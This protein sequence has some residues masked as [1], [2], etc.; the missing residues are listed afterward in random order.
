MEDY[1]EITNECDALR[2]SGLVGPRTQERVL[3]GSRLR[4]LRDDQSLDGEYYR[5]ALSGRVAF[6]PRSSAVRIQADEAK[7]LTGE[8]GPTQATPADEAKEM[9]GEPS[10][11]QATPA[12]DGVTGEPRPPRPSP[13]IPWRRIITGVI[14]LGMIGLGLWFI[15]VVV[16]AAGCEGVDD[17][18]CDAASTIAFVL[19]GL[20]VSLPG[21]PVVIAAIRPPGTVPPT[22]VA[23]CI[24]L[25]VA[26]PAAAISVLLVVTGSGN[27]AI[28]W[29]FPFPVFLF[30]LGYLIAPRR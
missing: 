25:P 28:L 12:D 17:R 18:Y 29:F 10:P 8:P 3:A 6:V 23:I 22:V 26:L 20:V 15:V 1:V 7:E 30:L 13:A 9:A 21:T 19:V 2:N 4:L 14:G 24:A 5:V 11:T 16:A 27:L